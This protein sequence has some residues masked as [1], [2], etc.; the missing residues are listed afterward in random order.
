MYFGGDL[1]ILP[2]MMMIQDED[3]GQDTSYKWT[4]A[5]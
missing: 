2:R 3:D 5:N 4:M 1:E